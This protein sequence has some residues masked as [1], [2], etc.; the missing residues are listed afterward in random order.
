V[1]ISQK[2][3]NVVA[4]NTFTFYTRDMDSNLLQELKNAWRNTNIASY[5]FLSN[6]P[7]EKVEE[8]PFEIR[9]KSFSW[10]FA[11]IIRTRLCYIE[12]LKTGIPNF[13]DREGIPNKDVLM[14][15][16]KTKMLELLSETSNN[17][18][19][20]IEKIDDS[21]KVARIIWLLQHERIHHGKLMLYLSQSG[22]K[23]PESFIKT[24]GE[25]NFK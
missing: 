21:H 14:K 8:K 22:F 13:E 23:L 25:S 20:E 6:I 12:E 9:F 7:F 1:V 24:W 3:S 19:E 11:C 17:L 2:S 10:E 16:S 4:K 5:G 15:E 18:L